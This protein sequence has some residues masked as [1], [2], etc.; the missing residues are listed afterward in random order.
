[1]KTD[2]TGIDPTLTVNDVI[3]RDPETLG[4]FKTFG[5]DACCGG[6]KTVEEVARR[7]GIDL[8]ALLAALEGRAERSE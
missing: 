3:A 2:E 5:I 1:M 8:D 6:A 7:H 4:I